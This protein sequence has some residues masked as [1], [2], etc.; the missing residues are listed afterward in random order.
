MDRKAPIVQLMRSVPQEQ[1]AKK[2]TIVPIAYANNKKGAYAME[3]H[4]IETTHP[5][6][7]IH[8]KVK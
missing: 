7:N 3:K 6:L 4:L 8:H 5:E 1:W 2:F